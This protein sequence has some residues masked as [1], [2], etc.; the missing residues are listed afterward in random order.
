MLKK[1]YS[2]PHLKRKIKLFLPDRCMS[3]KQI[4]FE[5]CDI[6]VHKNYRCYLWRQTKCK[7]FKS[8][9]TFVCNWCY[10]YVW[11]YP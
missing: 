8:D 5:N 10:H 6:S 7:K 9:I 4:L 11:E 1:I 2:I 3:C